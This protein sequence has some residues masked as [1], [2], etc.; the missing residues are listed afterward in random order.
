MNLDISFNLIFLAIAIF[1]IDFF[2]NIEVDPAAF[3]LF[4]A[5]AI[6]FMAIEHKKIF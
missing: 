2:T 6:I 1:A 3:V 5:A 4:A